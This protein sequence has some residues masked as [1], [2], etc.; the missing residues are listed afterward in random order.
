[1]K[2]RP[3]LGRL[4][5]M[6]PERQFAFHVEHSPLPPPVP[7][8]HFHPTRRWRFDFAW[9]EHRVAVEIDGLVWRPG[10]KSRHTT[11]AGF[12]ADLEKRNE[13][14]LLGWRVLHFEQDAVASGEAFETLKR[15]LVSLGWKDGKSSVDEGT[16]PGAGPPGPP[17][18]PHFRRRPDGGPDP[19]PDRQRAAKG[20][21]YP[22]PLGRVRALRGPGRRR[23]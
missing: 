6:T 12:R 19:E 14:T 20:A 1:M 16:E 13:A 11:P 22:Y 10:G 15:L 18:N 9:P 2:R 4:L 8:Y 17:E 3:R 7:Q 23:P 21:V 5:G